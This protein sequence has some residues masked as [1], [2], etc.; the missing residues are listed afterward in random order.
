MSKTV[1]QDRVLLP[2]PWFNAV[3]RPKFTTPAGQELFDG[4]NYQLKNESL[5]DNPG[6]IKFDFYT[7]RDQFRV[8]ADNG[9]VI[10]HK[11][12]FIVDG[13][14]VDV[15]IGAGTKTLPANATSYI[16]IDESRE[17]KVYHEVP[18]GALSFLLAVVTTNS[19][20]ITNIEDSRKIYQLT[21]N[22]NVVK[23]LGGRG[24]EGSFISSDLG[25]DI[26]LSQGEYHFSNFRIDPGHTVTIDKSAK[27][28]VSNNVLIYGNV[29]VTVASAGGGTI[30]SNTLAGLN[31]GLFSGNGQ[32]AGGTT[33]NTRYNWNV[34]PVGSGG[35]SG[36][37]TAFGGSTGGITGVASGGAGG[38]GVTFE[39]GGRFSLYGRIRANGRF[40]ANGSPG[41]GSIASGGGGGSGGTIV[42]KAG[43][44]ITLNNSGRLEALGASGGHGR[45]GAGVNT[46]VSGGGGGGGGQAVLI[47]PDVSILPGSSVALQGGLGGRTSNNNYDRSSFAIGGGYGGGNGADGGNGSVLNG[48]PNYD[49]KDSS[50]IV[51]EFRPT[52]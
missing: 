7:F 38:G 11:A 19:T 45:K 17:I 30:A 42:I 34:S 32:G 35:S 46:V 6:N 18:Y 50:L 23:T 37:I 1:A 15:F 4:E 31:M 51:R 20:S 3:N 26:T 16:Y 10:S 14:G 27:I 13:D 36:I 21:P 40:G 28:Y 22:G 43:E 48:D 29:D 8:L 44:S 33:F 39:V 49:G 5:D 2:T 24:D 25:G 41:A 47:S 52:A 9:L 12:G